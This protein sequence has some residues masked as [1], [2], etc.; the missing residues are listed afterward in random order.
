MT[1]LFRDFPPQHVRAG[2]Q[3]VKNVYTL[4]CYKCTE[5]ETIESNVNLPDQVISKKFHQKGWTI[6]TKRSSDLCPVCSGVKKP[7]EKIAETLAEKFAVSLDGEKVEKKVKQP[8]SIEVKKKFSRTPVPPAEDAP[9]MPPAPPAQPDAS[10]L[11]SI[12]S[13]LNPV[14]RD[15]A[16]VRAAVELQMEMIHSMS[17]RFNSVKQIVVEE[18]ETPP[19][20]V[21]DVDAVREYFVESNISP[22]LITHKTIPDES[23]FIVHVTPHDYLHSLQVA[24]GL[25]SVMNYKSAI[26]IRQATGAADSISPESIEK[27]NEALSKDW[28]RVVADKVAQYAEKPKR[29]L[30]RRTQF[31]DEAADII[32]QAGKPV[33]IKELWDKISDEAK[34]GIPYKKASAR[35]TSNSGFIFKGDGWGLVEQPDR[36]VQASTE[37][38]QSR[39]LEQGERTGWK[40]LNK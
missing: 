38:R 14:L 1:K 16:D 6:G 21:W 33:H 15:L 2:G 19:P 28:E 29:V 10:L 30:K 9:A 34:D 4:T 13:M 8:L 7:V 11:E 24:Q 17:E 32:R 31:F 39:I 27:V 12:A 37:A 3:H 22:A 40:D 36:G 25:E 20:K 18:A 23:F 35:L 26:V 5:S